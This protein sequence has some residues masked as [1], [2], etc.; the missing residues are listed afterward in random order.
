MFN[1]REVVEQI[2]YLLFIKG[3]DDEQARALD[4]APLLGEPVEGNPFPVGRH[5]LR[6]SFIRHMH[7]DGTY[8][9]SPTRCSPIS[10]RWDV[11]IRHSSSTWRTPVWPSPSPGLLLRGVEQ[12]V[13]RYRDSLSEASTADAENY[14]V[15]LANPPFGRAAAIVPSAGYWSRITSST[16]WSSCHLGCSNR[17]AA[18]FFAKTGSDGTAYVWFYDLRADG[19][20]LDHKQTPLL[21][22]GKLGHLA[23]LIDDEHANNLPDVMW[24][25][26]FRDASAGPFAGRDSRRAGQDW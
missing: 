1:P 15:M 24:R 21:D 19:Y 18:L 13:E 2:T 8:E 10:G 7:P 6:W 20:S 26:A 3:L 11:T 12:P 16:R 23:V 9:V 25:W 5:E 14:S 22:D 17:T 4:R